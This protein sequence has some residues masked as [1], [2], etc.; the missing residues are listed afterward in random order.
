MEVEVSLWKATVF[1]GERPRNG[2]VGPCLLY[3]EELLLISV[4]AVVIQTIISGE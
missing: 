3:F 1:F 2:T 4:M